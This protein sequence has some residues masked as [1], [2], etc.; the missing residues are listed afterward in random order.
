MANSTAATYREHAK[1]SLAEAEAATLEN[2]RERNLRAASVW[3][4]MADRQD[5]TDR[6]R[7][8]REAQI[9]QQRTEQA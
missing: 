4:D 9:E 6:N 3:R 2:V 8:E 1:R 7:A 5:R